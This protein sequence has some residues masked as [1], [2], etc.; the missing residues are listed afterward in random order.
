VINAKLTGTNHIKLE[1]NTSV[2][3]SVNDYSGFT[4]FGDDE[5][6]A[7]DT[8]Y[9]DPTSPDILHILL[10]PDMEK[11][12]RINLSYTPG[13]IYSEDSVK[14]GPINYLVVRNNSTYNVISVNTSQHAIIFPNP[15]D[16]GII[17]FHM[18]ETLLTGKATL[19]ELIDSKGITMANGTIQK[20]DG[21]IDLKG[22][23]AKGVYYLKFNMDNGVL[24][25]SIVIE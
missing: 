16:S 20:T 7:I 8:V 14:L 15:N 23:L 11:D 18:D 6:Y 17:N 13:T 9:R 10:V 1:F 3:D 19:Y 21:Q 5:E 24:T 22:M 4:V 25:K 12:K 2:I